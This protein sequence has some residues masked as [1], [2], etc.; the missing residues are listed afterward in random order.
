MV[1]FLSFLGPLAIVARSEKM[2]TKKG[3]S[4]KGVCAQ[5]TSL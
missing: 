3:L 1:A 5:K 4:G 2:R